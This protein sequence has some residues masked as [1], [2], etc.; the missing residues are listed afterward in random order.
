[1]FVNSSDR[2]HPV[3][4]FAHAAGCP[5]SNVGVSGWDHDPI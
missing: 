2:C 1:M 5:T 3:I 4:S